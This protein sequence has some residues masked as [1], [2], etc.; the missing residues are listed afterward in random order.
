MSRANPIPGPVNDVTGHVMRARIQR[1]SMLLSPPQALQSVHTDSS[2]CGKTS[3]ETWSNI[4]NHID[5]L[6]RLLCSPLHKQTD[7]G[8]HLTHSVSLSSLSR[9]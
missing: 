4:S 8:L 3:C 1:S 5:A 7:R 6:S 2:P 9:Q